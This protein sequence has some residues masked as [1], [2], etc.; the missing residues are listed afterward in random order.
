M[1]TRLQRETA[2]ALPMDKVIEL[3]R[4]GKSTRV[5]ASMFGVSFSTIEGRLRPLGYLRTL[6]E[7]NLMRTH[8]RTSW[9]IP[10][11][12]VERLYTEGQ[13]SEDIS[14][15]AGVAPNSVRAYVKKKGLL[16]SRGEAVRLAFAQ[17]KIKRVSGRE[18]Y[19]WRGGEHGERG[20]VMVSIGNSKERNRS[21]IVW[22]KA[23]GEPLPRG[24]VVHH[25]NGIKDDDRPE[26]L[27][28][29]PK[30]KHDRIT[31]G[32][33]LVQKLRERIRKLE[34]K[35]DVLPNIQAKTLP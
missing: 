12:E 18:H 2:K 34:G 16:R 17:G 5:I 25:L 32:I 19:K 6:L 14:P 8:G 33:D 1:P 7:A 35:T 9:L 26:N 20:Y 10:Y 4:Q 23:H 24:W 3:Y 31:F 11:Q 28:A 29:I 15:L 30:A 21:H 27:L 22:E 13:S